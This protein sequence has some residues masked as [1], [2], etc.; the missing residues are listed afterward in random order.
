MNKL[1]AGGVMMA[2]ILTGYP[3]SSA[4]TAEP[5]AAAKGR[6]AVIYF[7]WSPDGNTRF[8]AQTIAAKATAKIFEI[9]AEKPYSTNYRACCDEAKPECRGKQLRDKREDLKT[10]ALKRDMERGCV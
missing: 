8:A 5:V 3:H 10:R 2:G 1:I 9:K 6:V 4:A 7:S